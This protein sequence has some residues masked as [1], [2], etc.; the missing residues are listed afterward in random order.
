M[1][2]SLEVMSAFK[3]PH[4]VGAYIFFCKGEV[5]RE[6]KNEGREE[7]GREWMGGEGDINSDEA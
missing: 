6:E 2:T 5:E 7:K 3:V 1:C 4:M